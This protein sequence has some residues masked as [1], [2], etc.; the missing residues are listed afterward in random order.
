M[1]FWCAPRAFGRALTHHPIWH[2]GWRILP[3]IATALAIAGLFQL[4]VL[5][6]LEQMAYRS[7][8]HLRGE[9]PWDERLVLIEIDD[10]SLQQL[11][12]FPW[13]RSRYAS[14]LN[15]LSA[16]QS[17][18]VVFNLLWS[19][20]SSDDAALAAAI[21][22]HGRIVLSQA[23][24]AT[25][26]QLSP[27]PLLAEGAIAIG[28]IQQQKSSDGIVRT[29]LPY[30]DGE[31]ALSV[32]AVQAYSLVAESIPLPT[33]DDPVWI[34]WPAASRTLPTYSFVDVYQGLV[35]PETWD[36]KIVLVGVTA[37]G[38]DEMV[39]P[40][41]YE[42]PANSVHLHAAALTSLLQQNWLKPMPQVGWLLILFVGG[43][44]LSWLMTGCST[45]KQFGMVTGLSMS[46]GILSLLLFRANYLL[47]VA[48]PLILFCATAIAIALI[49]RLRES[50][51]LQQQI[52]QLW[53]M[54][55][56]DLV[57]PTGELAL[58][59]DHWTEPSFIY[60]PV[61]LWRI[62]Q[63]SAIAQQLGRSQST[64]TAIA[65]SLSVGLL[66]AHEDERIWFLNSVAAHCLQVEVGQDLTSCLV[67]HWLTAED[68]H[69]VRQRLLDTQMVDIKE[70]YRDHHW[71]ELQ[72]ELLHYPL[73]TFQP[74]EKRV[75]NGWL[76]LIKDISDR[77]Q[78]ETNLSRQIE[79]QRQ[80][81]V[82]KDDFLSTV[83]HEL[84]SPMA[85]IKMSIQ[86]LEIAQTPEQ[87]ERYLEILRAE[88]DRETDLIN[89]L[90]DLQRLEAGAKDLLPEPIPIPVWLPHIA[91]SFQGRIL[92][93]Q[94]HLEIDCPEDLPS[95]TTDR[96]CLE[97][98]LGELIHNACK[99]TPPTER[100]TVRAVAVSQHL[101]I[102][103][104][105]SGAEIPA[106]ELP[107]IFDKFYRVAS[108]DRWQQGG[109]G[110]GL[111]LIKKLTEL[112]G[113]EICVTSRDNL[114]TFT[115]QLPQKIA[116]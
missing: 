107:R 39:T 59:V 45:R 35:P 56:T 75:L 95:V 36:N 15:Q 55:Q 28:H 105:N 72:F 73:P 32:A 21:D 30:I 53:T 74:D 20:P 38:I 98:I 88:C 111:A 103:V 85:N 25:S 8:F 64:Q 61:S 49:E 29:L 6:P 41:D 58:P 2:A 84:R 78:I 13:S 18:V 42:P 54:Y 91:E 9:R 48:T 52:E 116:E 31:P 33:A 57:G 47:P 82:M 83:S 67:P 12:R 76:L 46:W 24:A 63:L 70:V 4:E 102:Q 3:G 37:T 90:L 26:E 71:Y 66:A 50:Q 11:G 43:P 5:R 104:Q 7:L 110:L 106:A 79:E 94:Q 113:G 22:Q 14:L 87:R 108:G 109:T 92:E 40:F 51:L 68:W 80:L 101:M 17:S 115:V 69:T 86:L 62:T 60:R 44:G 114:T 112:L 10:R 97:R 27:V 23:W 65:Q 100:I 93:R 1:R 16:S 96:L 34:N 77:K 19:E 89:D 81:N 99:Y